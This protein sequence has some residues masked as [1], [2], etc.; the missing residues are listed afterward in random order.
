MRVQEIRTVIERGGRR[1]TFVVAPG[2]PP[3][4]VTGAFLVTRRPQALE[5]VEPDHV[6]WFVNAAILVAHS[7]APTVF[8]NLLPIPSSEFWPTPTIT[9]GLQ[10]LQMFIA[11]S[12]VPLLNPAGAGSGASAMTITSQTIGRSTCQFDIWV[13]DGSY[14]PTLGQTVLVTDCN[15]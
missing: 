12:L 2:T 7:Q 13:A 8:L 14:Q 5:H 6:N 11:G 15:A 3:P 10:T 9:G 1:K 4:P